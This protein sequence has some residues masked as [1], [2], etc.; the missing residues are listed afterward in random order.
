M[1]VQVRPPKLEEAAEIAAVLN[2]HSQGIWGVDAITPA[3]VEHWFEIP[4]IT[5]ELDMRVAETG[6]GLVGY[7]DVN[8]GGPSKKRFWIDLRLLPGTAEEVGHALV[9]PMEARARER[10]ADG[11]LFRGGYPEPDALARGV[12]ARRGYELVRHSLHM[13]RSLVDEP[14][15][16]VW[17]EGIELRTATEDD[18]ERIW[19]AVE[20]GFA[21]HWEFE[22][23]PFEDFRHWATG[24]DTDL[25]LWFLPMEGEEIAGVCLCKPFD[26]G[27]REAGYVSSLSV[28]PPWRR[29]GLAL[30]LLL[31]SF[32][33][34]R[35]QGRK[36]VTLGVD[37]EN[38]TGAVRLYHRAGMHI[39]RQFDLVDRPID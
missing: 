13:E 39:V 30:A 24:P 21:D 33:E 20:E 12:F 22:R 14:E 25:A 26:A 35:E 27:D 10:A 38:T 2:A 31:H 18:M 4:G 5:P 29:R 34:L 16:P 37:A 19:E 32:R 17:P 36:R 28:R 3:H 11:A 15:E 8:D 7:A 6:G 1:D 9:E 23:E